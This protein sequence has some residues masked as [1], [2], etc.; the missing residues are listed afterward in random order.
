MPKKRKNIFR[1]LT[2]LQNTMLKWDVLPEEKGTGRIDKNLKS[3]FSKHHAKHCNRKDNAL[4]RHMQCFALG[5]GRHCIKQ[6]EGTQA[7]TTTKAL[8]FRKT[9]ERANPSQGG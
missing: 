9:L 8:D 4:H 5:N 7:C 3:G 1:T 2:C 6:H